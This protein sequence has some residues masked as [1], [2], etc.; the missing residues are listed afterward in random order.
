VERRFS[1]DELLTNLTIYWATETIGS[2]FRVYCDWALGA[3]S[4]PYAWE[5][6]EEVPRGVASKPLAPNERIEVPS[7]VA[8]FPADPP[9][10]MPREWVERSY[11]DLR[12][13][14]RMS[15][16]GHF[17]AMEEP[18]L[19]AE[20]IRTFLRPLIAGCNNVGPGSLARS[21]ARLTVTPYLPPEVL[22]ASIPTCHR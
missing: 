5:G 2:S 20:D 13:F 18:E 12:R 3:E 9:A 8:L 11:S 17:P 22:L 21:N 16:G 1:K 19:L 15:R 10:G 6:R 14:S 7:A 4:N